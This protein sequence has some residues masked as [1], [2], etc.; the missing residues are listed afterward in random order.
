MIIDKVVNQP[1]VETERFTLRPLRRADAGLLS[2]YAGDARVAQMTRSIPHPLPPGAVEAFIG[3]AQAEIRA[4]DVW[5]IDATRQGKAELMGVVSLRR[6]DRDQSEIAYWVAP[7]FWNTGIASD[8]VKALV[9]ANPHQA[10][11]I[12]GAVFQDNPASARVL[13]NASFDYLGD[14]EA[15]SVARGATVPT[16]TYIL[17]L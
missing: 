15:F 5:A 10:K 16:W 6:L 13:T 8:A 14:A 17:K 1:L 9:A 7:A 2:L 3:R 4:E 11:V 12:F